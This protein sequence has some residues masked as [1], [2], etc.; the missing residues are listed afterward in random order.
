MSCYYISTRDNRFYGALESQYGQPAPVTKGDEFQAVRLVFEESSELPQRRDKTGTRTFRGLSS[1]LRKDVRFDVQ[2]Y[3]SSGPSGPQHGVLMQAALGGGPRSYAGGL[4]TLSEG[5]RRLT[6][7]GAHGLGPSQGVASST[8]MRFV[9]SA[10]SSTE[11]VLNAPF[12][13]VDGQQISLTPTRTYGPGLELPSLTLY[14]YWNT[15]GGIHRLAR[16]CGVDVLE[17]AAAGDFHTMRFRGIAAEA[18][19]SASFEAGQGGLAQFPLEPTGASLIGEPTP[20]HLGQ[21]WIGATAERFYTLT[22]A[23]IRVANQLSTRAR[24]FGSMYPMCLV[25][26]EREVSATFEIFARS[27]EPYRALYQASKTRSPIALMLQLGERAGQMCGVSMP[28]F[29]PEVPEFDD[30]D[31]RQLWKFGQ[32]RAQGLSEDEIHVAFA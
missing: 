14:D 7:S 21:A 5:G 13:G 19:D 18:L 1:R 15:S 17:V 20:G 22:K 6:F 8:E 30:E 27:T 31:E 28:S 2:T 9:E 12:T 32:S 11:V 16:G 23:K 26:G 24:E 25:S 4:A 3:L 29:V 10:P